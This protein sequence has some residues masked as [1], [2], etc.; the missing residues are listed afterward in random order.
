MNNYSK[1]TNYANSLLQNNIQE[2]EYEITEYSPIKQT[3]GNKTEISNRPTGGFPPIYICNKSI[4]KAKEKPR[5]YLKSN[6]TVSIRD[7]MQ[8]RRINK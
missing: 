5:E 4:E 3:G 6:D 8:Q 7:I 1:I 2:T